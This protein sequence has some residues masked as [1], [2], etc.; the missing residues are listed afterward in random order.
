MILRLESINN[1]FKDPGESKKFSVYSRA[2]LKDVKQRGGSFERNKN[3][4]INK[5]MCKSS[6]LNF[7]GRKN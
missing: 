1:S 3:M 2:A 4:K 5:V 7:H 6:K